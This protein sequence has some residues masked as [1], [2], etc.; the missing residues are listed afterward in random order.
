[1]PASAG[2][3][4]GTTAICQGQ[5]S[6]VYTV[7]IISNATSYIWTLPTGATG[8]STTNSITVSYGTTAVSGNITVKGHNTIGDGTVSSLAIIVNP[9]P[10]AAGTITETTTVYNGQTI[11]DYSVPIITNATSYIWTLPSGAM[12]TSRTNNFSVNFGTTAVSGN[13]TVK[14]NN[15]CGDGTSSSLAITIISQQNYTI[16]T[17]A[18]PTTGGTTTGSG[19]FVSGSSK[20]VS[21]TA[22]TGY[23]FANWTENGTVAS[24]SASYTFTLTA[25]RT[26]VANFTL[27]G[28]GITISF[29]KPSNWSSSVIYIYA[30][31]DTTPNL[32]STW[33]GV[34]MFN[35]G[36][37]W[38][39]YTFA[40]TINNINVVFSNKGVPQTVDILGITQ[41][42]CFESSGLS[43]VKVTVTAVN[44]PPTSI[45]EKRFEKTEI[46]LYPNPVKTE[47]IIDF[48]GGSTFEIL[49]LMGQVVY[50]GN[51]IKSKIVQT[52]NLTSG[53]YMIKFSSGKTFEYKKLIKE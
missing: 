15:S 2:T 30:W 37:S 32:L 49:N 45:Y 13:I 29:K 9:L 33:P 47:L 51:L 20:T 50:N 24:T 43:G 23:T 7:P 6:I 1:M 19:T 11:F 53:V 40:Q 3:I 44:C 36:N 42:T 25:N 16:T 41:N 17:S 35:N 14:G 27:N 52:S 18:S 34:Q 28:S 39:S 46:K 5:N 26:L 21:A 4:T 22:N 38:Y 48:D 8:T 12:I 10:V 31:T